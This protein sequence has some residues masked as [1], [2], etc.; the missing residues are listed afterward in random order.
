MADPALAAD[1]QLPPATL[2]Q[3]LRGSFR[4]AAW[5]AI[6]QLIPVMHRRRV[7]FADLPRQIDY[8]T[9]LLQSLASPVAG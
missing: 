1:L 4:G 9:G 2:R 7:R 6:E 5:A 3:L 8:A